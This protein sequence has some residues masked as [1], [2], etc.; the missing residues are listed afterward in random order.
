MLR[1]T[2]VLIEGVIDTAA[3]Y[4]QWQHHLQQTQASCHHHTVAFNVLNGVMYVAEIKGC[5]Q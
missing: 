5:I 3:A 4:D 2:D 1:I